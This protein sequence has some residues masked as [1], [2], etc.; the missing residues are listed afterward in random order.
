MKITFKPIWIDMI[1]IWALAI[2]IYVINLNQESAV[3]LAE[4]IVLFVFLGVL[5]GVWT[6]YQDWQQQKLK[7]K[8]SKVSKQ[9]YTLRSKGIKKYSGFR[10][11]FRYAAAIIGQ[12]FLAWAC[13]IIHNYMDGRSADWVQFLFNIVCAL[14]AMLLVKL[15]FWLVTKDI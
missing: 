8:A 6:G 3:P 9:G 12:L 4:S 5:N 13:E 14:A 15:L 2:A 10:T 7:R 11:T 1:L